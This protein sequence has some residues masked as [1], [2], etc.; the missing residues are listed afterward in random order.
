MPRHSIGMNEIRPSPASETDLALRWEAEAGGRSFATAAGGAV[1]VEH[2]GRRNRDR[3]PDFLEALLA[4]DRERLRRGSVEIHLRA[5]DWYA[6]GHGQDD[7]Y[8]DVILHVVGD[9]GRYR[10]IA[11]APLIVIGHGLGFRAGE[12]S[13]ANPALSAGNHQSHPGWQ[14]LAQSLAGVSA[15][16]T[17]WRPLLDE[18]GDARFAAQAAGLEGDIAAVGPEQALYEAVM[19]AVG[20]SKNAVP[21]RDLARLVPIEHLRG[22]AQGAPTTAGRTARLAG[23]LFGATGMLPSQ[24]SPRAETSASGAGW[25]GTGDKALD[26]ARSA[27]AP[28]P[29]IADPS[30]PE[31]DAYT[32]NAEAEWRRLGGG[33]VLGRGEWHTFRVRPANGPA[34][35]VGAA[36][37]VASDWLERN[38][39]TRIREA[40]LIPD[41]KQ[42][43]MKTVSEIVIGRR[44]YWAT[45]HRLGSRRAHGAA[46]AVIGRA[47]AVEITI[48]ALLPFLAA[49]GDWTNDR[50]LEKAALSAYAALPTAPPNSAAQQIEAVIRGMGIGGNGRPNRPPLSARQ[51]QG[52]LHLAQFRV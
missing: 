23:V 34:R 17:A 26:W 50:A 40:V 15:A 30:H 12:V 35:R 46:V 24:R 3:G 4:F 52:L 6:H 2:P 31:D 11:G 32:D 10:V 45:H 43:A 37:E 19:T 41:P 13:G 42:A 8:G 5:S 29:G 44:G 27:E 14:A 48:N 16:G 28:P 7:C 36:V 51:Q 1:V 20:Y 49:L 21:F 22:L 38:L 18:L 33:D 39:I 25:P 9:A 47:R